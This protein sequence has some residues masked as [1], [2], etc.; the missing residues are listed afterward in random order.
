[1]WVFSEQEKA[2]EIT[3]HKKFRF[4]KLD[5]GETV[6]RAGWKQVV[7]R[8]KPKFKMKIIR[9]NEKVQWVKRNLGQIM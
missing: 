1:M 2:C 9:G 3:I 7:V 8:E 6:K 5:G 4:A